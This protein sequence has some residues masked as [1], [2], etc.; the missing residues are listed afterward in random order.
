MTIQFVPLPI[1]PNTYNQQYFN[2]LLRVMNLYFRA[3]N[4][5]DNTLAT[6]ASSAED[7]TAAAF[8]MMGA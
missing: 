2:E 6:T 8:L 7:A 3:L 1:P 4:N 5:V